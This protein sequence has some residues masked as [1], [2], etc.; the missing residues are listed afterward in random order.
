M[1]AISVTL[2]GKTLATVCTDGYDMVS[3]RVSGS[4]L[5]EHLAELEVTGGPPPKNGESTYLTWVDSV[6]IQ[7]GKEVVVSVVES[8]LTSHA[9]KTIEELFPGKE[10][11]KITDFKPP[12]EMFAE[13]RTRPRLRDKFSFRLQ[14]SSGRTFE[15]DTTDDAFAF[16]ITW[17][18]HHPE[19]ARLT[20]H[21]YT[22][23]ELEQRAPMNY[24]VQDRI[25]V[26]DSVR[27]VVA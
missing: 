8:G 22:F 3:V 23:E 2:D 20:L 27:F 12:A 25:H 19:R 6:P 26:G 10:L 13:L 1:P 4:R 16:G 14:A 11:P 18:S 17:I 7:A 9:G 21:S 5:D 24:H 15:G